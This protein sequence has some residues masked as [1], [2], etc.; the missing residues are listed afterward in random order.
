MKIHL[1]LLKIPVSNI[2]TSL[3]FYE[4]QLQINNIFYVQEYG[5]AQ[6][7]LDGIPF[8][9]YQ[10]NKGGGSR[11]LGGSVDFHFA[12]DADVFDDVAPQWLSNHLLKDNMIHTGNDGST[13]VELLDPDQNELKIIRIKK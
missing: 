4:E 2:E 12:M 6:F 3:K 8:A 7:D 13:F 9:L 10:I 5:W 11:T 1:S